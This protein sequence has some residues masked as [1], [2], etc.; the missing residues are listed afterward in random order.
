MIACC[1][2]LHADLELY[3]SGWLGGVQ[4]EA[5]VM[6]YD[7]LDLVDD[8]EDDSAAVQVGDDGSL[9]SDNQGKL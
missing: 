1:H 3:A 9:H 5:D 2:T 4:E 8:E 6:A 7:P